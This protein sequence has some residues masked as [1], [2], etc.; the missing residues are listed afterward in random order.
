MTSAFESAINEIMAEMD[1]QRNDLVRLSRGIDEFTGDAR[2]KRRQVSATVDARGEIV[3]LKFHGTSYRSLPPTELAN[4]IVDTIREAKAAAQAHMWDELG[5]VLPHG[6]D[7][8]DVVSGKHDWSGSLEDALTLP[9]SLMDLLKKPP[10]DLLSEI[11]G[12]PGGG[13]DP[14][15]GSTAAPEKSAGDRPSPPAGGG[16]VAGRGSPA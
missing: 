7:M 15:G 11:F 16:D 13:A 9:Q 4:V 3:E 12:G 6:A 5:D 8:A 2:S 14:D 1:K 10:A